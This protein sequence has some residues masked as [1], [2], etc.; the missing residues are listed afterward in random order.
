MR[1]KNYYRRVFLPTA[2]AVGLPT[3]R[4][5]DLRHFYASDLLRDPQLS[6]KDVSTR[7]GHA[8]ATLV[9]RTYGHLFTDSGAGLGD[10]VAERREAARAKAA[11]EAAKVIQLG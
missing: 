3:L 10:R 7:M 4:F 2:K 8:D 9:L 6:I 1:H 5:H 11:A